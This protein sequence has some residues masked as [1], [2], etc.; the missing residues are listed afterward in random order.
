MFIANF[1]ITMILILNDLLEES[2]V[3]MHLDTDAQ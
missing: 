1:G 3:D 2:I